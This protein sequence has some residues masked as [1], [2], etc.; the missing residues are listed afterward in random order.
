[1]TTRDD[2]RIRKVPSGYR[3][4]QRMTERHW[5]AMCDV[6]PTRED[7]RAWITAALER[8]A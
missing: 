6:W 5:Q 7:A 1:M 4:W 8:A 2:F 3:V